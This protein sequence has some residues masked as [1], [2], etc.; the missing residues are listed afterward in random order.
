M[1]WGERY[2]TGHGDTH[3]RTA[4]D[5]QL[6]HQCHHCCRATLQWLSLG[7]QSCTTSHNH[8]TGKALPPKQD[9]EQN[10][11]RCICHWILSALLSGDVCPEK[12]KSLDWFLLV[13]SNCRART[14]VKVISALTMLKYCKE[15]LPVPLQL[16]TQR[17]PQS[18]NW[19]PHLQGQKI[20][21]NS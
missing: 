1:C 7:M 11:L 18:R 9:L 16:L 19:N 14:S 8:C 15:E 20:T 10:R 12:G 6:C 17:S 2:P 21:I 4:R 3:P 13:M 5:V